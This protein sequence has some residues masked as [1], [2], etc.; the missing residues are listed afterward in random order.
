MSSA[1]VSVVIGSYNRDRF[2][3][4]TIESV[5]DELEGL[6]H[7]I[8]V[9]DGG[10]DDGTIPWLVKQKDVISIVQHNRG[11]WRGRQIERRSWGYFMNIAFRAASADVIC[12]LS[13]D[14][15]VI[16]GAIR[17]GL[18]TLA[19]HNS[20]G[21]R[22]GGVA[23][24]WRNWPTESEYSI[25]LTFGGRMFV[26]H[27][28]FTRAA[29]A[30]VDYIDEEAFAFY[31]ADGDLALRMS[32]RGWKFVESP[33]SFVEHYADANPVVRASNLATQQADWAAYSERWGH[34]GTPEQDWLRRQ[35]NDSRNTVRHYWGPLLTSRTYRLAQQAT[36]RLAREFRARRR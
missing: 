8:I 3:R 24:W 7:E 19:E 27:G 2:L 17:N 4:A 33:G 22:I 36:N 21:E 18:Q 5:R 31:H 1:R 13:D 30:D 15:L 32:E 11:E 25:G 34:L 35:Y 6:A 10:S 9:I 16:P 29:L 12:M 14:C 20:A 28:L 23:F 26:N